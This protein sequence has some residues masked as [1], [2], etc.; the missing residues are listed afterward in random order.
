MGARTAA[1]IGT[2]PARWLAAA[3]VAIATLG[4]S[5]AAPAYPLAQMVQ[6]KRYPEA[7]RLVAERLAHDPKDPQALSATVDLILAQDQAGRLD[8]ARSAAERCVQAHPDN[9]LCFEALGNALEATASGWLVTSLGNTRAMRD[10]FERAVVL[11]P[12]NYRAR[13]SLLRF[14]LRAPFFLG[15]G[16]VRARELAM[17]VRRTDPDLTRLM[18]ALC[19]HSEERPQDAEEYVL[20]AD[21]RDY[22]LVSEQH[23]QLLEALAAAHLEAK[24]YADSARLYGELQR[25]LPASEAGNYGLAQVARAQGRLADAALF[26]ERAAAIAARPYV[27]KT[28]GE[29]YQAMNSP[30]RAVAAY[31]A[32]LNGKPPLE[33][34]EQELIALRLAQLQGR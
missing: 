4:E 11:D 10:A 6:Q 21:L 5:L 8:E 25:R 9:S 3:L 23:Q 27:Y 13:M 7:A 33:R 12:G 34:R 26:L 28:L 22:P 30:R 15:A 16:T 17:E 2:R 19:A 18:L 24:R 14:Y 29:V 20:A 32:A 31:H 1:R